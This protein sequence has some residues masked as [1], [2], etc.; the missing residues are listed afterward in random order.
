M[1]DYLRSMLVIVYV[2]FARHGLCPCMIARR[3]D[4]VLYWI[5]RAVASVSRRACRYLDGLVREGDG[6]CGPDCQG[7]KPQP[8]AAA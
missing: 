3:I 4:K 2:F 1:L 7:C 8:E 6:V 5:S